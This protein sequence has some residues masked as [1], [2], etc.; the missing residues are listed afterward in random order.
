MMMFA[1]FVFDHVSFL[2]KFG[3]EIQNCLFKVRFDSKTNSN[4][5]NSMAASILFVLD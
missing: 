1:F 3:S 4:M 2:G 5:Q